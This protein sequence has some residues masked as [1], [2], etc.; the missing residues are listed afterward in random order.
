MAVYGDQISKELL[1]GKQV[2]TN[3]EFLIEEDLAEEI[4]SGLS[5]FQKTL[6]AKLFYDET[7]SKLFDQICDL[8]EYYL[9]RTELKIL[10]D[11]ISGIEKIFP[12]NTLLIEFGSGSSL[13]TRILLK[14]INKI[15]GYIPI[16]ISEEHLLRTAGE[17]ISEFPD[18]QIYS[19]AA[20]YMGEFEFPDILNNIE[21]RVVFFPGSTIGNLEPEEAK[22][23]FKDL[24]DRCGNKCSVLIGIDLV[25]DITL[26]EAAYND[27]ADITAEFNLNILRRLNR[28]FGYGFDL[29]KFK[30]RAFFN[31]TESRIE[32]H[33]VST[34]EQIVSNYHKEFRF[35]KGESIITEYSYKYT[36]EK[37]SDIISDYFNIEKIWMDDNKYFG[38]L[39]LRAV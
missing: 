16:D 28:E 34:A 8:D 39:F 30:H 37:F 31:S 17:L 12:E 26:L 38:V 33:L 1:K 29:T 23:F 5:R 21:N 25:K 4:K 13:K 19:L 27:N 6:P 24:V 20:D 18:L 32:M 22:E 14:G 9:T 10:N 15:S 35:K 3:Q 2:N 7:G 36:I 11:N